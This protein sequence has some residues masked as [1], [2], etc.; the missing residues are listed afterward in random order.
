[1]TRHTLLL[2]STLLLAVGISPSAFAGDDAEAVIA[3]CASAASV[4]QRIDCLENAIRGVTVQT[5]TTIAPVEAPT[6]SVKETPIE[7]AT[8]SAETLVPNTPEVELGAEQVA[9]RNRSDQNTSQAP[10]AQSFEVAS[11]RTVPYQKL[12]V[13]LKNGQVWRQIK[14][15]TQRIRVPRKYRDNLTAEISNGAVSGYKMRLVEMKRTIRVQRIK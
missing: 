13:T 8:A 7:A 1:M 11:T 10:E 14:G 15:D 5:E 6:V 12:E 3:Q 9:A 2:S 4:E